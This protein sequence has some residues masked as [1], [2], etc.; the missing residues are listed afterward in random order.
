LNPV[1]DA[2]RQA[3]CNE[4]VRVL[5]NRL[6]LG[7]NTDDGAPRLDSESIGQLVQRMRGALGQDAVGNDGSHADLVTAVG[8]FCR[9]EQPARLHHFGRLDALPLQTA[10]LAAPG[11]EVYLAASWPYGVIDNAPMHPGLLS[12][13]LWYTAFRGYTRIMPGEP[14]TMPSRLDPVGAGRIECAIIDAASCGASLERI[15]A[16][17]LDRLEPGGMVVGIGAIGE[18]AAPEDIDRFSS[19]SGLSIWMRRA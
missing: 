14:E 19:P 2:F 7:T 3:L 16:T 9:I 17:V 8:V 18:H 4:S 13:M 5:L 15:I 6:Q 12:G 10:M 11:M 1:W